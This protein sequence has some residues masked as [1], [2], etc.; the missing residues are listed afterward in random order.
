M[1]DIV[2]QNE[3]ESLKQ[4]EHFYINIDLCEIGCHDLQ[5]IMTEWVTYEWTPV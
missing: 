2:L 3:D 1:K 4:N 5:L